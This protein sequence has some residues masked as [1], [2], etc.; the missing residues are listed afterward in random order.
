MFVQIIQGE[1]R[2]RRGVDSERERWEKELMP[3]AEGFLGS[4]GGITADGRLIMVV[5]FDSEEAARRNS[6]RREQGEWWQRFSSHLTGDATFHESTDITTYQ[7][8]GDDSAGFVQVMQGRVNDVEAARNLND[9]MEREMPARRP[10]LLGGLTAMYD[11]GAFTDVIYFT[12]LEEARRNEKAMSDDPPAE[13][14]EWASLIE[15]DITYY[16]LEQPWLV[17]K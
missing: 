3:N 7:G 4:T 9:K 5:R 8:G 16:D 13:M 10:D 6:A 12:S 2:D 14:E 15:G 1:V 11:D 17:S